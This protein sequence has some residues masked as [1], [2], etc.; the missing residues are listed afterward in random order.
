MYLKADPA[1]DTV[2]LVDRSQTVAGTVPR[3]A[4]APASPTGGSLVGLLEG[5][6]WAWPWTATC[7][8]PTDAIVLPT[9]QRLLVLDASSTCWIA[10]TDVASIQTPTATQRADIAAAMM[11]VAQG[12]R[13]TI[14]RVGVVTFAQDAPIPGCPPP[15]VTHGESYGATILYGDSL[16]AG[17][18][19]G[20]QAPRL[21]AHESAHAYDFTFDAPAVRDR[22]SGPKA[23]FPKE[24]SALAR[25]NIADAGLGKGLRVDA[26]AP[27][28]GYW[29]RLHNTGVPLGFS[30]PYYETQRAACGVPASP[31]PTAEGFAT[32][33]GS[34]RAEDDI[35]EYTAYMQLADPR[36]TGQPGAICS[37]F[38]AQSQVL[39][40]MDPRMV[41]PLAKANLLVALGFLDA[42]AL[43]RCFGPASQRPDARFDGLP[44]GLHLFEKDSDTPTT[45]R[46]TGNPAAGWGENDAWERGCP[47][48]D[49]CPGLVDRALQPATTFFKFKGRAD[50]LPMYKGPYDA[51][52]MVADYDENP[53]GIYAFDRD[54]QWWSVNGKERAAGANPNNADV[55][56]Q[57][58]KVGEK[59][60]F[61]SRL[62]YLGVTGARISDGRLCEV[63]GVLLPNPGL[64]LEGSGDPM[65]GAP[66]G[67]SFI[68]GTFHWVDSPCP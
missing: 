64:F 10:G 44:D 3:A 43:D 6:A 26:R 38:Q 12:P 37:A 36:A 61:Q 48:W 35:A 39:G 62:G 46:A 66:P 54:W 15:L 59:S 8:P 45:F 60:F 51:R 19:G 28:G 7:A 33:Y 34:K 11:M 18:A 16:W 25:A 63:R 31:K 67:T 40:E 52:L 20:K 42:A 24:W 2:E 47:Q 30:K 29:W 23:N 65:A 50:N 32:P 27:D 21:T 49:V 4:W 13:E 53:L 17:N 14:Q 22:V 1:I 9:G 68:G 57:L 58:Q 5:S 41:I 56:L 55:F